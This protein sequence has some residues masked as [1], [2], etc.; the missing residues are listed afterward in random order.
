VG[1]CDFLKCD[2]EGGEFK[3]FQGD[4]TWTLSV[5]SMS[6]EY[7]PNKGNPNELEKILKSQGFKVKRIDH[8]DLGYFYCTRK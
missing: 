4:L 1:V 7:H 3:L 2:V 8:R 5:K 6:L